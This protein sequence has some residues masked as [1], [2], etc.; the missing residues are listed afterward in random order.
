MRIAIPLFCI[1]GALSAL[2]AGGATAETFDIAGFRKAAEKNIRKKTL[3]N[4]MRVILM[5][6]P[7]SPTIA[8]YLKIGVG[9]ANESFDQ[10]GTA[11]FLEH[12]LFKGTPTMGTTNYPEEKKLLE[13]I[14]S[15]G[16]RLDSLERALLNPL[17]TD[18][19]R[20]NLKK[21]MAE[22]E[23]LLASLQAEAQ[24]FVI[25]E[26][27]SQAYSLAG[28]VG[29]NAYTTTDVTNYQIKLPANRLA[30][31]AELE[32]NRFLNPVLRE[33]YPERKVIQ[34]ERR[35]RYDSRPTSLLYELFLKTAF[36]MSPYGKPVIGFEK[37]MH[38]LRLRE[39]RQFFE[40][41]YIPSR[42][43]ITVVGELEFDEAF[44]TIEKYFGRLK[45]RPTPE[46]PPTVYEPQRGRRIA[47]LEAKN[48]PTMITGWARP[49]AMHDDDK[50][51]EVLSRLLGDGQTSRL[52]NRLVIQ[53]KLAGDVKVGSSTPGEK[54]DTQFTIFADVFDAASYPAIEKAIAEELE[55]LRTN[56]PTAEELQKIKNRYIAEIVQTLSQNAGMA[57]TLSYYELLLNDYQKLFSSLEEINEVDAAKIKAVVAKYFT[58]GRNTTVYLKPLQK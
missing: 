2:Q 30:M 16:E 49:P 36:G 15:T 53:D 54:L 35:M 43:V 14:E 9:S 21:R 25:S 27:D 28:Q 12:L 55:R 10:A 31:W 44:A 40:R 33:F 38:R 58:D 7:S 18:K 29:Y 45:A 47:W 19:E 13:K 37:S 6:Q 50:A 3:P 48:S 11:H 46:F 22:Q 5:R 32:S 42:M 1:L 57:D 24:A 56:G 51:L 20:S 26:E 4:G 39:T 23:K 41:N 52:V 34:E 8:C 17:I